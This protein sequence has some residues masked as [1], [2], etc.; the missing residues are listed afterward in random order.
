MAPTVKP[1]GPTIASPT[2]EDTLQD[3]LRAPLFVPVRAEAEARETAIDLFRSYVYYHG[4][5][6]LS[7]TEQQL[8]ERYFHLKVPEHRGF[9]QIF[10]PAKIPSLLPDFLCFLSCEISPVASQ[11]FV[12]ATC[13]T[14]EELMLW[15]TKEGHID[16]ETGERA[17][18][19]CAQAARNLPRAMRALR[20]L[21]REA[22]EWSDEEIRWTSEG[23]SEKF[24]IVRLAPGAIWL[25]N[26]E[27]T[28]VG[29]LKI[30]D[31]IKRDLEVGWEVH[32]SL[33]KLR[34]Q[35]QL[36]GLGGIFPYPRQ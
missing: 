25:Q 16:G 4:H 17:A 19:D 10:G 30:S 20:R 1:A 14:M 28:R 22:Q 29:P 21:H 35:W 27:G 12:V 32:C 34:S 2:I 24:K 18:Y 3:F 26:D 5:S 36:T 11:K 13:R 23:E 8:L 9:H 33:I 7:P 6:G 31:K 15:L